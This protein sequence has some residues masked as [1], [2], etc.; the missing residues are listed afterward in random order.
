MYKKL[1]SVDIFNYIQ[2]NGVLI[3]TSTPYTIN[4]K[5]LFLAIS[6]SPSSFSTFSNNLGKASSNAS[7]IVN[8]SP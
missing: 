1:S 7:L 8:V 5:F 3:S 4:S 2:Y 6:R